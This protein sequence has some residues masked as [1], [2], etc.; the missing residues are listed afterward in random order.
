VCGGNLYPD[1]IKTR[2]VYPPLSREELDV[3]RRGR[4]PNW[5]VAQRLAARDVE[6]EEA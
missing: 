2:R 1:E 3:P 5:L 4:P 6:S